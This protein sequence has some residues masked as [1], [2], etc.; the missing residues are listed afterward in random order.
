MHGITSQI[1]QLYELLTHFIFVIQNSLFTIVLKL[2]DI[3]QE[4]KK[5]Y[6]VFRQSSCMY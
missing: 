4:P 6:C 1:N 2:L 3:T 5:Y